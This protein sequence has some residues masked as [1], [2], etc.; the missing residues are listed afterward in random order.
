LLPVEPSGSDTL[1]RR[2]WA[3]TSTFVSHLTFRKLRAELER[4]VEEARGMSRVG[5]PIISLGEFTCGFDM[6]DFFLPVH[7]LHSK[8]LRS[9]LSGVRQTLLRVQ[10]TMEVL[11]FPVSA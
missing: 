8:G 5:N 10:H 4:L 7:E 2:R 1:P 11:L 9:R 3:Q 6:N